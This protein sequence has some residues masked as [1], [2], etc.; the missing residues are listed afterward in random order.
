MGALALLYV[1]W[2]EKFPWL[3]PYLMFHDVPEAWVGDIP[4]P[5]KRYSATVRNEV[6]SLEEI[7]LSRLKL[8]DPETLSPDD[9]QKL[10]ACDQLDLYLWAREQET[11]GNLHAS[12]VVREL[13]RFFAETPLPE[14][15]HALFLEAKHGNVAHSTDQLTKDIT[16]A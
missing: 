14:P 4:A 6:N 3:S 5:L 12:C 15:A 8:P 10:K 9:K 11:G 7:I 13:E 2:P 16:N 1:L